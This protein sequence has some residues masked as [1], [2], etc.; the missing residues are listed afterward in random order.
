MKST[1]NRRNF[2]KNAVSI[3]LVT[4]A[5]I[6][7][8]SNKSYSQTKVKRVGD[9]DIKTSCC[10]YSYRKYFKN[11][12]MNLESYLNLAAQLGL[13]GVELTSYYFPDYPNTPSDSYINKIKRK[14]FLLGLDICGSAVKNNFTDPDKM[15]REKDVEY[16]RAWIECASKLGAPEIRI[17][18]GRGIPDGHTEDEAVDWIAECLGKCLEY[19]KKYGVMLALENHRGYPETP[20]QLLKILKRVNSEWL[21]A[22]LD[23]GNFMSQNPY[24]DIAEVAPYAVTCHVKL[25]VIFQGEIVDMYKIVRILRN[26]GYR[27]YISIEYEGEEDPMTGVPKFLSQIKKAL[28]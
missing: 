27:G 2:L 23:A 7:L 15:K 3:P 11:G 5:G 10:A 8:K 26:A 13:D 4:G 21:G 16:V 19:S 25:N 28:V 6:S 12:T 17:F 22:N 1:I 9:P 20:D 18:G 24:K 14:A